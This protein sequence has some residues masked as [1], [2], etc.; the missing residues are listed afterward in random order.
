MSYAATIVTE[1][2]PIKEATGTAWKKMIR[3]SEC[4]LLPL[5]SE[6]CRRRERV[7]NDSKGAVPALGSSLSWSAYSLKP[8]LEIDGTPNLGG[9]LIQAGSSR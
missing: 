9:S 2:E 7:T 4:V 3:P 8:T 5:H 6:N 1:A